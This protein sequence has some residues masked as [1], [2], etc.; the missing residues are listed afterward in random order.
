MIA[1]QDINKKLA[2]LAAFG[3][4]FAGLIAVNVVFAFIPLRLDITEEGLYTLSGGT[5]S[6]LEKIEDPI[7]LKLYYSEGQPDVPVAFKTYSR[8]VVELLRE[9]EAESDGMLVLEV[10]NPRPDTDEEEWATRYG[11]SPARLPSGSTLFFG[12]V[13]IAADK[14]AVVPFFD[15]RKEKQLEFEISQ[16]ITQVMTREKPVV[17][18]LSFLPIG[19]P[20]TQAQRKP[21]WAFVNEIKKNAEVEFLFP[22]NLMEIPERIKLVMLVHPKAVPDSMSYALDQFLLRGGKLMVMVDPNS[23][24]DPGNQ[25]QMGPPTNSD[26]NRLLVHWGI[27]Y[28]PMMVV[29][30]Q[31]LATRVNAGQS[32]VIDYPVWIT[33]NANYLND[34]VAIT[35]DLEEMT[36]VDAGAFSIKEGFEYTFTPLISTSGQSG[37]LDFTTVRMSPPAALLKALKPDGKERVLAALVS[38]TF[39]TAFAQGPPPEPKP[40]PDAK[41]QNPPPP[42]K[43]PHL[44]KGTAETSIVLVGDV[45]FIADQF[46]VDVVNFFGSQVLQPKNDNLNFMLNTVEFM[47]GS[48]DLIHVRSRGKFSRPFTKVAE[49]QVGAA[50]KFKAEEQRLSKQLDEVKQRLEQLQKQN[51]AK[52]DNKRLLSSEQ[53]EAVKQFRE[54]EARTKR[55]LRE[56]RKLLREDIESLGNTLLMVNLLVVPLMVGVF[57]FVVIS[58]RMMRRG[59]KK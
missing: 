18:I 34:D 23:R 13:I 50:Q 28:N 14:E 3:L 6:I 52:G 36:L 4:L 41:D 21:E 47:L 51:P 54:E 38:G 58:R 56:V 10:L 39:N 37:L 55:A 24:M 19:G 33:L 7:T 31:S 26:L 20:V 45:D 12:M 11:L 53:L 48:Q 8:K 30:D 2:P 15:P 49:L 43:M 35:S 29:G 40:A 9:Y 16:S 42:R 57:G 44:A 59:G 27:T 46:S 17:G 32:G 25:Q 5:R 1:K 22:S